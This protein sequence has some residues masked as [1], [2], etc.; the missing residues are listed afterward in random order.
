ML[1]HLQILDFAII[2][3]LD[4]EFS[5]GFT[6]ISGETGAGKSILVDA[7][8]LL[9]GDRSDSQWVRAGAD[10]AELSAEFT[11]AD[12]SEALAWLQAQELD[13]NHD[14]LL[15]RSIAANGRSRAW[16]NGT[17]VT[18]SQLAELGNLLVEL[19]GQN[20]HVQL[21]GPGRQLQLLDQ[22]GHYAGN[23]RT[24][25]ESWTVWRDAERRYREL[26]EAAAVPAGELDLLR[27]QLKELDAEDL[28]AESI[29]ETEQEHRILAQGESLLQ[30]LD[31]AMGTLDDENGGV[32][33]GISRAASALER[34]ARDSRPI[35]DALR[36]L[37][38]ARINCQ[39][40]V[41]T[42]SQAAEKVDL[43]PERL[44]QVSARLD[45]LGD[46]SRKHRVE[47]E[48]LASVREELR[49][50]LDRAELFESRRNSIE[51]DCANALK[52]YRNAALQLSGQRIEHAGTLSGRVRELMQE[53]GMAGGQFSFEVT[54]DPE[55]TPSVT[56]DDRVI[57]KV[58]ANPGIPPAPLSK[59]ASG[60]ELSRISL[61][62]KVACM[63]SA[64]H[65]RTQ[66]FDEVDA[67]VGGETANAV[68]R[69]LQATARHGQA[70]CVTHLAQV[71]VRADQQLQVSKRSGGEQT[72]VD[73]RPLGAEERVEE[74]A[75]MLA[76]NVSA[77]SRAHAREMLE[78][79]GSALH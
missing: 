7:L 29:A 20:E 71:A 2:P 22:T 38:E 67:G 37:Q 36:M 17:P 15:R 42:L 28:T 72:E 18:V 50:R 49:A 73:T 61:A 58:S 75:R 16:I 51:A 79:A 53:L 26:R 40:A 25:A 6:A 64:A 78:S 1:L 19:H 44:E 14:C 32:G 43:S 5:P 31:Q 11:I 59:I 41:S 63:G 23:L 46:L 21:T 65:S 27:H 9:L 56:G 52:D 13:Q 12:N 77:Q 68:G 70:L 74:V 62:I 39:E 33:T 35:D 24:V 47:L 76:G 3:S 55:R 30:A 57:M 45:R 10:K 66:V 48:A 34:F 60:G 54:H 8:G 69:M 4:L